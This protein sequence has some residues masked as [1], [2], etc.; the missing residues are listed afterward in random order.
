[1]TF[2]DN[3]LVGYARKA[4]ASGMLKLSINKQSFD[5]CHTYQTSDGQIYIPITLN[6]NELRKVLNG[7]RA[8]IVISQVVDE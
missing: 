1:M 2:N 3:L 8:V 5:K 6:L 7:E 4:G